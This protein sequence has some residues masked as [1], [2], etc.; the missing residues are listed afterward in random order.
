MEGPNIN[1][2]FQKL[3]TGEI[4]CT[5]VSCYKIHDDWCSFTNHFYK[6]HAVSTYCH[7]CLNTFPSKDLYWEHKKEKC[8]SSKRRKVCDNSL[9]TDNSSTTTLHDESI[10]HLNLQ[11]SEDEIEEL[12]TDEAYSEGDS[13]M[14]QTILR[15]ISAHL[16]NDSIDFDQLLENYHQ[17]KSA[18]K[19]KR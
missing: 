13:Q 11:G 18:F 19:E 1:S 12:Q 14:Q 6:T 2:N 8:K 10:S 17:S 3:I 7:T 5:Y 15:G 16:N 4:Q 9:P